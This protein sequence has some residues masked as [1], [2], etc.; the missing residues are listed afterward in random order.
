MTDVPDTG[1]LLRAAE[2]SFR[3]DDQG[4]V[5]LKADGREQIVAGVMSAF[6]LTLPLGMVSLRDGEGREIGILDEVR[7]LEPDSRRILAEELE[8]SYFM[9]RITDIRDVQETLNVVE[10]DVH[11]NKGPRTFQVRRVRQNVRRMGE[12]RFVIKDVDGNRYEIRD[13][14]ELPPYAQKLLEPYL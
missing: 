2:V 8:R 7:Q 13:W 3:R 4:N 14:I 10:W 1:V 5:L 12:R 9:P 6:P 11:T